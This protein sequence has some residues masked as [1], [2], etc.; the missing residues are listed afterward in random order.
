MI[1]ILRA[2]V[3]RVVLVILVAVATGIAALRVVVRWPPRR[4]NTIVE[5]VRKEDKSESPT[6]NL[7]VRPSTKVPTGRPAAPI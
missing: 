1:R 3:V 7:E 6:K 4:E 5:L 2:L